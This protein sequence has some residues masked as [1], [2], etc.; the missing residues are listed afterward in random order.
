MSKYKLAKIISRSGDNYDFCSKDLEKAL[1]RIKNKRIIDI[2]FID[3]YQEGG[4]TIDYAE[5]HEDRR[6]VIGFNELGAWLV[7]EGQ[8]G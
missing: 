3:E 1:E 6:I 5:E 4:L 2:G 7:W 8:T